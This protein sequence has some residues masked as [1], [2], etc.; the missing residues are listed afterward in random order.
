[1]I[2]IRSNLPTF[3]WLWAQVIGNRAV[4]R[5][6]KGDDDWGDTYL[7]YDKPETKWKRA[8]EAAEGAVALNK[9]RTAMLFV[10]GV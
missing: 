9:S 6:S 8:N 7:F 4:Y 1:M 2:L 5:Q 3:A 10:S